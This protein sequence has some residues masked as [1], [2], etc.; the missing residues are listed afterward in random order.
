MWQ[1]ATLGICYVC[2]DGRHANEVLSHVVAGKLNKQIAAD[3]GIAEGTVKVHRGR[4][5]TKMGVQ[6]VAELVRLCA[7]AE[8][9]TRSAHVG[10]RKSEGGM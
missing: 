8:V 10:V 7:K 2:S 9:E 6:S 5:M 4:V 1:L 3:L